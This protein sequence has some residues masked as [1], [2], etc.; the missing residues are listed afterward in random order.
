M[1]CL[2]VDEDEL[3]RYVGAL[4]EQEPL[5]RLYLPEF[6][7]G[8][9]PITNAE[10]EAFI[11]DTAYETTRKV[12]DDGYTWQHPRGMGSHID[13]KENHP[14]RCVSWNDAIEY[15]RWLRIVSGTPYSL[16]S[17]AEW[18]KAARGPSGLIYPWGNTWDASCS[19]TVESG[20]GD[21]TP[22][23]TYAP[24]GDSPYGCADMS[25]NVWE[26][27]RSLWGKSLEAERSQ[28]PYPYVITDGR[29]DLHAG[30]NILRV[31]RGGSFDLVSWY[32]RCAYRRWNL[33]DLRDYDFGF[34]VV[35]SPS[36]SGF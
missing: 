15:C 35:V 25:G 33:P 23:G 1:G 32:A 4:P 9:Y 12:E 24:L 36:V 18:E 30:A 7:I 26:W 16:P 34:R 22:V 31:L 14:V 8:R 13:G 2:F 17:E 21:T 3:E 19:N 20:I 6:W 29:E 5:H 28:Y 11:R 27:T 10:F